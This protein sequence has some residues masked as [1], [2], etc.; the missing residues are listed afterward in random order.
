MN[1]ADAIIVIYGNDSVLL[2]TRRLILTGS[3]F[4]P[5]TT[6]R[7]E[8]TIE[9]ISAKDVDLLILCSSLSEVESG[10]ILTELNRLGKSEIRTLAIT[11]AESTFDIKTARVLT[12]PVS[13]HTFQSVVGSLVDAPSACG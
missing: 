12:S 10:I 6:D 5:I 9:I 11:K 8:S 7:S 3:G 2:E 1:R 4:C 13:P